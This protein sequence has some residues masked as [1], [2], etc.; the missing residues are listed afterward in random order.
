MSITINEIKERVRFLKEEQK[1]SG[2]VDAVLEGLIETP[3]TVGIATNINDDHLLIVIAAYVDSF[4]DS[5]LMAY[6]PEGWSVQEKDL[7]ALLWFFSEG[8][9]ADKETLVCREEDEETKIIIRI[10]QEMLENID[11]WFSTMILVCGLL[12]C[13]SFSQSWEN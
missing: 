7:K 1:K 5:A 12:I 9:I 13:E 3:N 6:M 2:K 8:K 10:D 4:G 11:E